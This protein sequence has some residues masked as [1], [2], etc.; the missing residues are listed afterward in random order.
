MLVLLPAILQG[1]SSLLAFAALLSAIVLVSWTTFANGW[2]SGEPREDDEPLEHEGPS[3]RE[4]ARSPELLHRWIE[5]QVHVEESGWAPSLVGRAADRLRRVSRTP[6]RPYVVWIP[7]PT[8]LVFHH[9]HVYLSR[10][11]LSRGLSEAGVAFVLAH[12]LAHIELGHLRAVERHLEKVGRVPGAVAFGAL[13]AVIS[14]VVKSRKNELA[15]DRR[16]FELCVAA[17][18]ATNAGIE[19]FDL[20]ERIALDYRDVEGVF[21]DE[22]RSPRLLGSHPPIRDRR[23]QIERLAAELA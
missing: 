21:G 6:I 10:E 15:A 18:Y 4:I 20:L 5:E 9:G 14:S 8:A 13:I 3:W 1:N 11:L 17:G 22:R 2:A 19:V 7:Q 12:E 23:E 16:A